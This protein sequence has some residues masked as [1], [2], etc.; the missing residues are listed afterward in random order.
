MR[1]IASIVGLKVVSMAEGKQLGTVGEVVCDLAAGRM[2]G[3]IIDS[4]PETGVVS[5]NIQTLGT[6]AVMVPEA[7]AVKPLE[8]LSAL[9]ERRRRPEQ[10]AMEVITDDGRVLGS[11]SRIYID[12]QTREVT[13]FEVSGGLWRDM[14][15][16][17]LILPHMS[18]IIHGADVI[19]VPADAE[20]LTSGGIREQLEKVGEKVK[21]SYQQVAERTEEAAKR[22]REAKKEE[23]AREAEA[24]AA[25]DTQE[26]EGASDDGCDKEEKA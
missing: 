22:G 25:D 5:E 18:G 9:V 19:I 15:E 1:D 6:H 16:G 24:G 21:A 26:S 13:R 17:V 23:E 8:E 20:P 11:L 3:V 4:E 10:G 7:G 14:T 12:P 2:V